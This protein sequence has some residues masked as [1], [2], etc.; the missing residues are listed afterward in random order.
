MKFHHT[1]GVLP[2]Y[3]IDEI[4]SRDPSLVHFRETQV[5]TLQLWNAR[6]H[7]ANRFAR[8]VNAGKSEIQIYTAQQTQSRPGKKARFEGEP[9]C[10]IADADAS[11]EFSLEMRRFLMEVHGRNG[12]DANGM[13]MLTTVEFGRNYNNAFWDGSQMTLGKGDGV[14]FA[15]FANRSVYG[16]EVEHGVTEHHGNGKFVYRNEPGALNE[17]LSDVGGA[18]LEMF[19][20]GLLPRDFHWVVGKGIFMPG[21]NGLGIRHMLLPGTG[22]DDKRLGKDPQPAKWSD[23]YRGA[24]DNGGVHYNSGPPNRTFAL[25]SN[26]LNDWRVPKAIWYAARAASPNKPSVAQF[27]FQTV[28]A[29][30]ALGHGKFE[31]VLK[32]AWNDVEIEPNAK[33]MGDQNAADLDD[34]EMF[35]QA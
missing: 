16:H 5:Q 31:S 35:V 10:G 1:H 33:A 19:V 20:D 8:L 28:E 9:V 26:E 17:H 11:Y 25:F 13:A 18:C 14:I 15:T 23:R 24:G 34:A 30:K 32:K 27:A 21:I 4:V 12:I 7:A 22:Y 6:A 29:A 2:P 3:L